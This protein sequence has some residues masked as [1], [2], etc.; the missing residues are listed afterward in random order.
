MSDWHSRLQRPQHLAAALAA[1]GHGCYFL[2]PHLGRQYSRIYAKDRGP[3][4]GVLGANLIEIHAR[5][6][7]EPVYHHR[8][9]RPSEIRMLADVM[10]P[11]AAVRGA[12]VVQI[13]GFP[14]WGELAL[15]LR[16]RHGWPIVYDC[17]D[18]L[19]GFPNVAR[20]IVDVECRLLEQ[21]DFVLFSSEL[22][23]QTYTSR[24]S[25][26]PK[27]IVVLRNAV[28]SSFLRTG[29]AAV[30][31]GR[32]VA[33][34]FG[35]LDSWFDI[36]PVRKAAE[37]NPEVL[38]R[39]IGRVEH[40]PV[41]AL[42]SLPNVELSGEVPHHRLPE[43]LADFHVGLIPFLVNNLT[44][45]ANPIKLYEYFSAGIPVVSTRLPEVERYADVVYLADSAVQFAAQVSSALGEN[46]SSL[47]ERRIEI[48]RS[49]TWDSR[50][51]ELLRVIP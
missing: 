50:A 36:A 37:Q 19:E 15:L 21:A 13:L 1:R 8:L 47:R 5:L 24:A 51:S 18:L 30:E 29:R 32:K 34:Y 39:L 27:K 20:E 12:R 14:T 17:H 6:P 45:A 2:N 44:R 16:E 3:K 46:D 11:I 10:A 26:K 23:R 25:L 41:R 48:A 40:A 49:E 28:D 9:L 38:F 43:L 22:L 7:A 42:A 35:A 4:A 33:G 31:S